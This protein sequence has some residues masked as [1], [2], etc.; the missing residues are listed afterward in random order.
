MTTSVMMVRDD[1][2]ERLDEVFLQSQDE[3]REAVLDG[4]AQSFV[5]GN[6]TLER[7]VDFLRIH[8]IDWNPTTIPCDR[9]FRFGN[10]ETTRCTTAVVLP[11]NFAGR[12]GHLQVYVLE[13]NTPFLFP[14]PL[15][16]RF[17]L[18]IDYG[19]KLV[20]W[21]S[22]EWARVRQR[23]GKGHYLLDLAEDP[24]ALRRNLRRPGLRV[25]P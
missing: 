18:V 14:R 11:V 21:S 15:M 4:G 20:Q 23:D 6:Q 25:R 3:A 5:V 12:T 2:A 22:S 10:D 17:K 7:Y 16:E 19:R 9:V 24:V 1:D 13:G 8:G